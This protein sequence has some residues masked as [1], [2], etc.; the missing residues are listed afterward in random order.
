MYSPFLF[1]YNLLHSTGFET[2]LG[3]NTFRQTFFSLVWHFSI[4]LNDSMTFVW[5]PGWQTCLWLVEHFISV[6]GMQ[7]WSRN[8]FLYS[9]RCYHQLT[10]L[11]STR[12]SL[13][14]CSMYDTLDSKHCSTSSV[15]QFCSIT[16]EH[17][18]LW[19]SSQFSTNSV[20]HSVLQG[21][22][23]EQ[24]VSLINLQVGG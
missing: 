2:H 12:H 9:I 14:V 8:V 1:W 19:V 5:V 21:Q 15:W 17:V 4:W 13:L 16:T 10:C 18:V 24:T 22:T 23:S 20:E 11:F 6:I 7:T 3:L